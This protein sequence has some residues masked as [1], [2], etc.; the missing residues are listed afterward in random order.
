MVEVDAS[1]APMD[2]PVKKWSVI[3]AHDVSSLNPGAWV[4]DAGID[5]NLTLACHI[6]KG[7]FQGVQLLRSP[8]YHAWSATMD[9]YLGPRS[10]SFQERHLRREWP[11]VRFPNAAVELEDVS[12]HIFPVHARENHWILKVLEKRAIR[13]QKLSLK[14]AQL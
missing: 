11:P 1:N 10:L 4:N 7:L 9:N 12:C 8:K 14:P 5:A 13:S 2:G 6:S 3:S